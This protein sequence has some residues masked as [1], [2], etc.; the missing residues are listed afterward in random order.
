MS[1]DADLLR[2]LLE[3]EERLQRLEDEREITQL[4]A[5]YGPLVDSGSADDVAELWTEQGEYDVDAMHL[6]GHEELA[7]MVG[8][9][10][11]QGLIHAG[12]AHFLGPV[13]VRLH[14]DEAVAVCYSLL[15][16]N[17]PTDDKPA[18][19]FVV[20]RS[21]AHHWELSRTPAG[22]RTTRR[23]SRLLDGREEARDL[24]ARGARGR[25]VGEQG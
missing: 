23:T 4:I 1:A 14:G 3:L 13:V 21:T 25:V 24:L 5:R 9:R 18:G 20:R 10:A 12:S 17:A 15:V 2:R 8:S 19:G 7:A 11:H 6:R 16:V 22:W